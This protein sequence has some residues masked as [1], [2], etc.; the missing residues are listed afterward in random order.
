MQGNTRY[1]Y[2]G[3]GKEV[4]LSLNMRLKMWLDKSGE[5]CLPEMLQCLFS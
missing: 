2:E 1:N 4:T 3:K 5:S